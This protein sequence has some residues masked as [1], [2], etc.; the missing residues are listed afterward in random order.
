MLGMSGDLFLASFN[1]SAVNSL[2][3]KFYSMHLYWHVSGLPAQGLG[4]RSD[5]TRTLA[6]E[7][8][9]LQHA[10]PFLGVEPVRPLGA[11]ALLHVERLG[12]FL[13]VC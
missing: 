10:N 13:M 7:S 5:G 6:F 2:E 4:S 8:N 3:V 1:G 12:G 11:D 9:R